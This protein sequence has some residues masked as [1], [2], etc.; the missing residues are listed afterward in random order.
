M[1]QTG[2]TET[3]LDRLDG[4]LHVVTNLDHEVTV[5]VL[6]LRCRYFSFGLQAGID[7]DVFVVGIHHFAGDHLARL[8]Y[9][10]FQTFFKEFS[11]RFRHVGRKGRTTGEQG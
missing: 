10:G 3:V 8:H 11:K 1:G 9:G 7:D 4:H 6:E 5:D 2:I